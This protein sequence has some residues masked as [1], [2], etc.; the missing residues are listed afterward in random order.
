MALQGKKPSQL[1]MI[2]LSGDVMNI[3]EM[4]T[5]AQSSS[6]IVVEWQTPRLENLLAVVSLL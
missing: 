5:Y 3:K 2:I 6:C 1:C 4:S